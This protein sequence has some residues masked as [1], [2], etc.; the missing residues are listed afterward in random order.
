[1]NINPEIRQQLFDY[2]LQEHGITLLESDINEVI[3]ILTQA[4]DKA[5][6]SL[7]DY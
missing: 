6:C 5:V 3:N 2:F 7:Q 4:D 1:M